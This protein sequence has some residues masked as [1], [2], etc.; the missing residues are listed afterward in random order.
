MDRVKLLVLGD[1]GVGKTELVE[2]LKCKFLRSLFRRRSTSDLTQMAFRSTHGITIHQ[3]TIPNAKEFSI[4]DFS[5]LKDYYLIH[6]KFLSAK[7]SIYVI[8]FSLRDPVKK[9]ITRVKFWLSV[10]KAKLQLNDVTMKPHIVL[11]ASFADSPLQSVGSLSSL[12]SDEDDDM[13]TTS[14]VSGGASAVLM[15]A[16]Q[17]F[18][19]YF[20][21]QDIVHSLDCRLSQTSEMRVLRTTLALLRITCVKVCKH[22]KFTFYIV[23][24]A[25]CLVLN[26]FIFVTIGTT[27]GT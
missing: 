23:I 19:H 1:V 26:W 11:V 8:V 24:I 3:A 2:S 27:F 4:W 14:P 18:G 17:Q 25:Y 5:G 22:F 13:F 21:F 16:I 15:F 6:E 20:S 10:I 9:Q 7:N 12:S